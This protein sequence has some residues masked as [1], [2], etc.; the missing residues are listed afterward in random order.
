MSN[1]CLL[2]LKSRAQ[3]AVITELEADENLT[4]ELADYGFIPGTK[5]SLF[6]ETP[7][8]GPIAYWLR[9]SKVA[10]RQNEA[11]KIKIALV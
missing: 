1:L 2:D 4:S 5:V 11:S 6:S 7:F 8:G 10:I 9:Q 3:V